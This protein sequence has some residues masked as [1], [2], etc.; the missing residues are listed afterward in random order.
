M[1]YVSE[2]MVYKLRLG[3]ILVGIALFLTAG[4]FWVEALLYG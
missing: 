3:L 2:G 4:F 1:A